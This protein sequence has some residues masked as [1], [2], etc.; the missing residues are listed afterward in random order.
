M[1][2]HTDAK[3]FPGDDY[4][5]WELSTDRANAARRWMEANG[6]RKDQIRQVRGFAAQSLRLPQTPEDPANR[7]VTLLIGYQP[8]PAKEEAKEGEKKEGGHG[9]EGKKEEG[10]KEE[11]KRKNRKR[12][13]RRKRPRRRSPR[14]RKLT[15]ASSLRRRSQ[16]LRKPRVNRRANQKRR[17]RLRQRRSPSPRVLRRNQLS[18]RNPP[19][20]RSSSRI[21]CPVARSRE[22]RFAKQGFL[23][24]AG[25]IRRI[26]Q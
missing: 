4:S 20:C 7:R 15:A 16:K 14:K 17:P 1:E 11:G 26:P 3:P 21:C 6:L 23:R 25:I 12:R 5:N 2:G 18:L 13:Q 24:L 10:K 19:G 8:A 22:N 9:E